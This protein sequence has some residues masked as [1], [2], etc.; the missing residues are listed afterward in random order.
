MRAF[1]LAALILTA[2]AARA[3][4]IVIDLGSVTVP[5]AAI[6]DV[7]EWLETQTLTRTIIEQ[8]EMV[9]PEDGHLY[10]NTVRSVVVV[11]ETPIAKL[12][13]IMQDAAKAEVRNAIKAFRDERAQAE[14]QAEADA[15]PDPVA[16]E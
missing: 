15:L 5:N 2:G 8:V 1:I 10:T 7:Q 13:R 14:A 4:D 3:A 9:D 11:D 12:T 16:G 6:A